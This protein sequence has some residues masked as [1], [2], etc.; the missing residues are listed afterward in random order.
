MVSSWASSP[1]A[2]TVTWARAQPSAV[3]WAA[4][5]GGTLDAV[6][7]ALQFPPPLRPSGSPPGPGVSLSPATEP[8]PQKLVDRVRSGR[9]V[10]MRD[11]LADNIALLQQMETFSGQ[12]AC[13]PG[14]PGM[15]KPSLRDVKT[16]P[17]WVYS[18]LA[19]IAIRTPDPTTRDMLSYARLIVR[20]AQRHSG[21]GWLE[22][23]KVFRQQAALDSN[24]PWNVLHQGIQAAT[25]FGQAPSG[26]MAS[27]CTLCREPDHTTDHCALGYLQQQPATRQPASAQGSS[28]P[29]KPRYP[30]KRRPEATTICLSW[31]RGKCVYPNW[32]TFRHVCATCQGQHMARDCGAAPSN[33]E[34]ASP[35]HT[36]R[37]AN[38][39]Q[40]PKL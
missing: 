13:M 32:C 39:Y 16:L 25:L 12:Y 4:H 21:T 31:N 2:T 9:Y 6:P 20:E 40:K 26:T 14:L 23:D 11:L 22:Y 17:S 7:P 15:L 24:L 29:P 10:D 5:A 28:K 34:F 36:R 18:F 38:D 37:Q 33:S 3:T 27:M 1:A 19:Y 35:H 30:P 8:F